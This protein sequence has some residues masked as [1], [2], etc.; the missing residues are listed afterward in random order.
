[1]SK[2]IKQYIQHLPNCNLLSLIPCVLEN[3]KEV[4]CDCG[5]DRALALLEKQK[6]PCKACGGTGKKRCAKCQGVGELNRTANYANKCFACSGTGEIP[7]PA[8]KPEPAE[9]YGRCLA[10]G[11]YFSKDEQVYIGCVHIQCYHRKQPS[12][13]TELSNDL[14]LLLQ[15]YSLDETSQELIQKTCTTLDRQ[16]EEHQQE[17]FRLNDKCVAMREQL[18]AK[19]NQLKAGIDKAVAKLEAHFVIFPRARDRNKSDE[20]IYGAQQILKDGE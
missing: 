18:Q 5:L 2:A 20:L 10:C 13:P 9:K 19:I 11:E 16:A 7:C 4:G 6:E 3:G 8:C 12:E 17:I 14:E 1:M 15:K